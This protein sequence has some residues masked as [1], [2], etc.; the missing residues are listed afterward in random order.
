MDSRSLCQIICTNICH[1]RI[2]FDAISKIFSVFGMDFS[3][4][5]LSISPHFKYT[6][7]KKPKSVKTW[8]SKYLYNNKLSCRR[9]A[10]RVPRRS[11]CGTRLFA[12]NNSSSFNDEVHK[13]TRTRGPGFFMHAADQNRTD[14][15]GIFRAG[16]GAEVCCTSLNF[17]EVY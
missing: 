17:S 12:S 3:R 14:D 13:K 5:H 11:G 8:A 10:Q 2:N 1:N 7:N 16:V 9:S 15:T 6:K 4:K